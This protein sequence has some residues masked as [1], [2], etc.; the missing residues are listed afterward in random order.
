MKLILD[1]P[2]IGFDITPDN[3]KIIATSVVDTDKL[4]EAKIPWN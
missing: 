3:K 4:F 1:R 2:V